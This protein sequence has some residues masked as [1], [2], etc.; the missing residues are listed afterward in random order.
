MI[1]TNAALNLGVAGIALAI[2]C[3]ILIILMEGLIVYIQTIRLHLYEWFT[4][5]YDGSGTLFRKIN[6]ETKRIKINW[7]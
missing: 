4:K 2:I 1:A 3:N 7:K 6:P 5:F